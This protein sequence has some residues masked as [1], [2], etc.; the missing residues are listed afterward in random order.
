MTDALTEAV[1]LLVAVTVPVAGETLSQFPPLPVEAVAVKVR[2][3][4]VLVT[5]T[6]RE[7]G[8]RTPP[9]AVK[10]NSFGRTTT[11]D[12]PPTRR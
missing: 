4:A 9:V 5:L 1:N 3:A 10:S 6:S 7:E 8:E 11:E 2:P 12:L